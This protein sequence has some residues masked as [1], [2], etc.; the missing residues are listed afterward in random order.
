MSRQ[1]GNPAT[2]KAASEALN[3]ALAVSKEHAIAFTKIMRDVVDLLVS[4]GR[5]VD[6]GNT[7]EALN[8]LALAHRIELGCRGTEPSITIDFASKLGLSEALE[9]ISD[10]WL[11]DEDS[12]RA[13]RLEEQA[14]EVRTEHEAQAI[15]IVLIRQNIVSGSYQTDPGFPVAELSKKLGEFGHVI[16]HLEQEKD[17]LEAEE[18][19]TERERN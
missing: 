3:T 14:A 5:R 1:P 18:A 15:A 19:E 12:Q 9:P 8:D 7:T 17:R 2:I 10:Q 11:E 6:A 4:A 13:D 16:V